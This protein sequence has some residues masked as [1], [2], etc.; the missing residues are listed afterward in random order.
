[1]LKQEFRSRQLELFPAM[2][3]RL[4]PSDKVATC[5]ECG[6]EI[7]LAHYTEDGVNSEY[8]DR[9]GR[10][11]G[12][13]FGKPSRRVRGSADE[14]ANR[15]EQIVNSKINPHTKCGKLYTNSNVA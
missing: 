12:C 9:R 7:V 3:R 11:Y 2:E 14:T 1:M 8:R 13:A 4:L 5:E 6:R 15:V 10:C